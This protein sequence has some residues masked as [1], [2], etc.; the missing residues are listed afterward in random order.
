MSKKLKTYKTFESIGE[1]INYEKKVD[2]ILSDL[3]Q[4]KVLLSMLGDTV[5]HVCSK[6]ESV[7][8]EPL[9]NFMDILKDYDEDMYQKVEELRENLLE[10]YPNIKDMV[11]NVEDNIKDIEKYLQLKR[12]IN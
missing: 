6:I 9:E 10:G 5:N 1:D 12:V 3:V 8:P 11:E 2:K 7:F 4:Y